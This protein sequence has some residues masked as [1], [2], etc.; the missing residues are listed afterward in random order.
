MEATQQLQA[1]LAEEKRLVPLLSPQALALA[2]TPRCALTHMCTLKWRFHG[3]PIL[4]AS[5]V[6]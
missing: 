1:S 2:S 4:P 6:H 5:R 3:I